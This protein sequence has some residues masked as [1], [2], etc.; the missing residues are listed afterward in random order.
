MNT[1]NEIPSQRNR[2]VLGILALAILASPVAGADEP[3]VTPFQMGVMKNEAHG[4]GIL[5]GHYERAISK[6]EKRRHSV[7]QR[8][9]RQNNLCVAYV[10]MAELEKAASACEAAVAEVRARKA[11]IE[12]KSRRSSESHAYRS[13]LAIALSNRGVL[14][15]V[16][17][18]TTM[19]RADFEAVLALDGPNSEVAASNLRRLD[20]GPY[21]GN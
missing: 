1:C 18:D 5:S 21:S 6:L 20:A 17:G 3:Q 2:R 10:K 12:K 14:L 11:R 4:R 15:A 16:S 19:A 13:D 9:S 7:V 8:F